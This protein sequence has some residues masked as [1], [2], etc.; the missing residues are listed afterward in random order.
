[1]CTLRALMDWMLK[2]PD[3]DLLIDVKIP[4]QE[5]E[6]LNMIAIQQ[7]HLIHRISS[8]IKSLDIDYLENI[9]NLGYC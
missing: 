1:M 8:E 9:L 3:A 4:N 7:P 5:L 6:I 2:H